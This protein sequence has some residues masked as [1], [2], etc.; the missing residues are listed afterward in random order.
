MILLRPGA[1]EINVYLHAMLADLYGYCPCINC[2]GERAN[3]A[4][5][6]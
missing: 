6:N 1:P 5:T 4:V 2:A 3:S